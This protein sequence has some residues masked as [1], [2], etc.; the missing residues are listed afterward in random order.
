MGYVIDLTVILNDVFRGTGG[1]VSTNDAQ[2]AIDEHISSGRRDRI[3]RDIRKFVT[4]VTETFAIRPQVQVRKDL[5][6]EK[7]IELIKQYCNFPQA[8]GS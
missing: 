8:S 3:H 4:D 5:V 1:N 6:L 2:T 7:I